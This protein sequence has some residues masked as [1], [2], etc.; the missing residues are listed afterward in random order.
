MNYENKQNF[1]NIILD[2]NNESK[3]KDFNNQLLSI[4]SN[5][6]NKANK[7]SKYQK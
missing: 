3:L 5:I 4:D 2:N 7:C 6:I 1:N